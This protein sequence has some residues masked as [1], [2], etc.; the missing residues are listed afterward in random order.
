MALKILKAISQGLPAKTYLYGRAEH[1]GAERTLVALR[2]HGF[3]DV[4]GLTNEGAAAITTVRDKP[5]PFMAVKSRLTPAQ[6][7]ALPLAENDG[8]LQIGG[9]DG[10]PVR[11]NVAE[12]LVSMGLLVRTSTPLP[13]QPWWSYRCAHTVP[14]DLSNH[15]QT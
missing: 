7:R 8:E 6:K 11:R 5:P 1:G 3:L 14:S 4:Q 13:D 9:V 12:R 15:A 2:K 10:R